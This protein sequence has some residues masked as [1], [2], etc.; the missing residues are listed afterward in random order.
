MSKDLEEG[1]VVLTYQDK[2]M[3]VMSTCNTLPETMKIK[4][5]YYMLFF[6]HF[7]LFLRGGMM[8]QTLGASSLTI[9]AQGMNLAS[10]QS[11]NY[12]Q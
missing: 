2:L 8:M 12:G 3:N 4:H 6:F 7:S 5:S 9:D 10:L 1:I 11:K